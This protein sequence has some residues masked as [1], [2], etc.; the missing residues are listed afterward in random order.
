[1]THGDLHDLLDLARETAHLIS[2]SMELDNTGVLATILD[3]ACE[4][5]EDLHE[6]IGTLEAT[7]LAAKGGK[8]AKHG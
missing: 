6:R 7:A 4:K 1:M 2:A 5:A 8:G 3:L